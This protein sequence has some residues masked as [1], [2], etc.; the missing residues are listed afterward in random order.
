[1]QGEEPQLHT[2]TYALNVNA[3]NKHLHLQQLKEQACKI[4]LWNMLDNLYHLE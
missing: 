2:K 1:M 4:L 3:P